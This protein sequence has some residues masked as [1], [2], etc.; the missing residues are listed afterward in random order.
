MIDLAPGHKL[1]LMVTNPVLLAG[2]TI[3]YGEA[4]PAGLDVKQLGAVVV[5]PVLHHSS[6]GG[7]PPR[8]AE[9]PGGLVLANGLQNR[10]VNDVR[11]RFANQWARLGV[12]VIVQVAESRPPS[13]LVVLQ[14][15]ATVDA[16]A[17]VEL[18]IAQ[19]AESDAIKRTVHIALQLCDVPIW[20]KLPLAE[21]TRL[22]PVAVEAGA[23]GIVVGQP[24]V[25]AATRPLAG[26]ANAALI[27][28]ALYGPVTFSLTLAALLAM[29]K[30]ALPAAVIAC[31]G[32]HTEAQ[33]RSALG[34]PGVQALQ[35]DSAL[36]IEPGLPGRLAAARVG[37]APGGVP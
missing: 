21:V 33:A 1:G 5:G 19:G 27:Q 12:P 24:P 35:I 23:V 34:I 4:I 6:S 31:G 11:K 26:T 9:L 22:A 14:Q 37:G 3:G 30:L 18:V 36:W 32:I 8:L 28:G 13:L 20:V 25:A 15:L 10:G 7:P 17:G 16:V 2:G 29:S